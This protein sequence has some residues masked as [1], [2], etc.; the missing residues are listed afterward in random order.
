MTA[1]LDQSSFEKLVL[2]LS[3]LDTESKKK[4]IIHLTES[5]GQDV[6]S[7]MD[8]MVLPGGPMTWE[9]LIEELGLSEAQYS[10]GDFVTTDEIRNAARNW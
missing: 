9:Q 2:A 10:K 7:D 1:S 6:H 4:L 3:N 8:N 5:I